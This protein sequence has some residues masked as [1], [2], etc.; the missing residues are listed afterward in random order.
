MAE[1]PLSTIPRML[2][3]ARA[4][5]QMECDPETL[6]RAIRKKKL[7]CYRFGG[8]IRI[9]P[10]Q[11]QAFLETALCPANDQTDLSCSSTEAPGASS[12]GKE[13]IAAVAQQGRR[14]RHALDKPSRTSRPPLSVVP[15]S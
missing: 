2:T 7:G 4:A 11:L 6:R 5:E 12:G 15:S 8:C 3:I 13:D 9:S 1:S 10:A 14:L